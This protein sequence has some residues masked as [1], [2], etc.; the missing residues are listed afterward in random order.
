MPG[1]HNPNKVLLGTVGV[2]DAEI[3]TESGDPTS[4]PAG[5]AVRCGSDGSLTLSEG[6]IMGVSIGKSLHDEKRTAV[7]RAGQK[8]PV[9]LTDEGAFASLVQGNLTFT[10]KTKGDEGNSITV[11]FVD[12]GVAGSEEVTV[13]GADIVV[14]M[15][16]AVSTAQQIADALEESEEAMA[17]IGVT[18]AVG[19][20]ATA[21]AAFA[22]TPLAGGLDSYPYVI[23]GQPVEINLATGKAASVGQATGGVFTHNGHKIGVK[24]GFSGEADVAVIDMVGGL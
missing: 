9:L 4:F 8:V 1:F 7:A 13:T 18:I 2:S 17:L 16:A 19:Q 15:V 3:T 5:T 20:E 12:G 24:P 14:S 22:E 10:A 6:L 11:A 23:E 21:Q